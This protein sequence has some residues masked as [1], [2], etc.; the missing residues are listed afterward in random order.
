[1]TEKRKQSWHVEHCQ[2]HLWRLSVD[3][4]C[5]SVCLCVWKCSC[6]LQPSSLWRVW[7]RVWLKIKFLLVGE[8]S[9]AAQRI[10]IWF[11]RDSSLKW[12]AFSDYTTYKTVPACSG[13]SRFRKNC[14]VLCVP[15]GQTQ[16]IQ[17]LSITVQHTGVESKHFSFALFE[18]VSKTGWVTWL[19]RGF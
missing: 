11:V 16:W 15:C 6:R 19:S 14:A 1:M 7:S 17:M 4:L 18:V 13:K 5:A 8:K 2:R 3:R 10:Q 12:K 9:N